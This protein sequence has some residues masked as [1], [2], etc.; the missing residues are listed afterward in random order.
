MNASINPQQVLD[1][2]S[3]LLQHKNTKNSFQKTIKNE[4]NQGSA[5]L[6]DSS[7]Y[8]YKLTYVC[9]DGKH[10]P[11]NT[12]HKPENCWAEH[13]ELRPPPRNKNKSK[14]NEPETHQ[15]GLQ[16][17]L[18]HKELSD[19]SPSS[20]VIDCGATHHMF[21]NKNLFTTLTP[22]TDEKIATSNPASQ[23]MCKGRGTV[24]IVVNS[25]AIT[26]YNRLY[27]P[28]ITR[29]L[30]SLL[31]LCMESITIKRQGTIFHLLKGDHVLL[32]GNIINK[33]MIVTFSQPSSLLTLIP[34][35]PWHLC[36]G[37]PG[38]HILKS[39]GLKIDDSDPCDICVKGKMTHLPFKSHFSDT[40]MPLDCI[41]MDIIGPI[42]P[43][44][45]S[46]HRYVL[47]IIDQHT[48]FKITRFFKKK[49]EK[50]V[51]DG[52][53]EFI[54]QH[55]FVHSV[56]PPYTP[57]HNGIAERAN[58]TILDKARCLLLTSNL[59]NQYWEEAINTTTYLTNVITTPSKRNLSPYQLWSNNSP[60]INK[61]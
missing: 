16:A 54:N 22:N 12:T 15:T 6:T 56:A 20:L 43:P 58:R 33:L 24:T 5:L 47:T 48:S 28:R 10:N 2:L 25:K 1:K 34:K 42:S 57:E 45:I 17:L 50:I 60:R 36:L 19:F 27:V 61:I 7:S 26:L 23:L 11:K 9:R 38:S 13:P 35:S 3:E 55:G 29:N 37:H 18:M 4:E 41:H 39:L 44:S 52:G 14:S 8:A 46:G 59:P 30:V 31:K 49:S 53:G 32:S 51:T 40:T 21:H